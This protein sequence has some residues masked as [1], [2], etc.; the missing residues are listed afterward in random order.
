MKLVA[1]LLCNMCILYTVLLYCL[2]YCRLFCFCRTERRPPHAPRVK[3][4]NTPTHSR[5]FLYFYYFLHCRLI[6]KTS[7]LWNNTYGIKICFIFEIVQIRHPL[8]WWPLCKL[9]A[10]SQP[11]Y[12]GSQLECISNNRCALLKVNLWN[13]LPS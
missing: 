3:S 8:P 12:R 5:V 9:L 6:V 13:F 2:M 10:F 11:I 7:K 4:L 1:M